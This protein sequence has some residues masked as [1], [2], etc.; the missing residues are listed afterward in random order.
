MAEERTANNAVPKK[1]KPFDL[2]IKCQS[3]SAD[4]VEFSKTSSKE[5]RETFC[6][7]I[8]ELSYELVHAVRRANN[9][10]LGTSE[11]KQ[12]QASAYETLEKIED[13]LPVMRKCRCITIDQEELLE[14]RISTI[15][16]S[17]KI[18]VK[19]D[20]ERLTEKK[21]NEGEKK[22]V[23]SDKLTS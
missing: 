20:K 2:V 4:I 8:E 1:K 22:D 11:R 21:K 7:H 23:A 16:S 18:W 6:K 19:S 5:V 17:F 13:L 12:A 9:F 15:R 3:L 10:A 14:K